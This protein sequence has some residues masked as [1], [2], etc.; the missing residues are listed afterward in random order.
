M[1]VRCLAIPQERRRSKKST[2]F[3]VYTSAKD[4]TELT[5]NQ[6]HKTMKKAFLMYLACVVLFALTSCGNKTSDESTNESATESTDVNTGK[7]EQD[8]TKWIYDNTHKGTEICGMLSDNY[9]II[10]GR[11]I[12][13]YYQ[14]GAF[15]TSP[16]PAQRYNLSF[17]F[18]DE[19]NDGSSVK[20]SFDTLNNKS[21]GF[22]WDGGNGGMLNIDKQ[23]ATS[24]VAFYPL[25]YEFQKGINDNK[26]V[27]VNVVTST[28][29]I[30][31]YHFDASQRG[32]L[33]I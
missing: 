28:G 19:T 7:T 21:V 4:L 26:G 9:Y 25:A 16:T 8:H 30:L 11:K 13:L 12:A 33:N 31:K 14:F 17:S 10:D 3:I 27:Y 23:N 32:P 18:I 22:T 24:L 29:Q 1:A 15:P 5:N 2:F 20:P 6:N